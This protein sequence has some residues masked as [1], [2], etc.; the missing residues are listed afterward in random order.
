MAAG[1]CSRL[2]L[3]GAF[4]SVSVSLIPVYAG[5][6]QRLDSTAEHVEMREVY[7]NPHHHR[8]PPSE[9]GNWVE[10]DLTRFNSLS[11]CCL[12]RLTLNSVLSSA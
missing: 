1:G 5:D 6:R 11:D 4:M 9:P 12:L 8:R 7:H 10:K 3:P 2:P